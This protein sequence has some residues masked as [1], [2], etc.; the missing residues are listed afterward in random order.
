MAG[1]YAEEEICKD[2]TC[3]VSTNAANSTP[4][5]RNYAEEEIC[6]DGTYNTL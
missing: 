1:N 6:K 2:G 5:W 3:N 4:L